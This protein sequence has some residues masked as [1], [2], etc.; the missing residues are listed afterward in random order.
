MELRSGV[1]LLAEDPIQFGGW[2]GV[3][4]NITALGIFGTRYGRKS[5]LKKSNMRHGT[6]SVTC[7]RNAIYI[8]NGITWQNSW[9]LTFPCVDEGDEGVESID[10]REIGLVV[11]RSRSGR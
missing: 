5:F 9:T 7:R 8:R 2:Q 6:L 1:I 4:E 10:L 3:N 11:G